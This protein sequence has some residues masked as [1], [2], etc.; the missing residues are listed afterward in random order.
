MI[1]RL[2]PPRTQWLTVRA[3]ATFLALKPGALRKRLER[4]AVL[5]LDGVVEAH[6]D[7]IRG[8]KLGDRWR[9]YIPVSWRPE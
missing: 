9:I 3:A 7:G 6:L 2:E 1:A 4:N 8:R 5:G